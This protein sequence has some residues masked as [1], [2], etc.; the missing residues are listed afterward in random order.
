MND[1]SR[2]NARRPMRAPAVSDE[3]EPSAAPQLPAR[4]KFIQASLL[5]GASVAVL[6]PV[7]SSASSLN[8]SGPRSANSPGGS[9]EF[10]EM[11]VTEMQEGM[12]SGRFTAHSL[13]D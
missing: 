8:N 13:T 2:V 1:D 10:D 4:R 9:F 6:S 11:T 12:A 5:A 3:A 7:P